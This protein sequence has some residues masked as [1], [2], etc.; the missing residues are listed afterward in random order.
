M[1]K[2]NRVNQNHQHGG[3]DFRPLFLIRPKGLSSRRLLEEGI[4]K[5]G[6]RDDAQQDSHKKRDEPWTRIPHGSQ[7]QMK[8]SDNYQNTAE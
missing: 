4:E 7:R 5:Y 6:Q 1:G 2:R 8:G 3:N